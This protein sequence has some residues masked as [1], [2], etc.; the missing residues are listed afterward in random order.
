MS[1]EEAVWVVE[2]L[3]VSVAACLV[4]AFELP[5]VDLDLVAITDL[6]FG[7]AVLPA[8]A[9]FLLDEFSVRTSFWPACTSVVIGMLFHFASCAT[10]TEY[11]RATA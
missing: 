6:A 2:R 5:S 1:L 8:L 7:F 4:V 11:L 10:L 9:D 3:L